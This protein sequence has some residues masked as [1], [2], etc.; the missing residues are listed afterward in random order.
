[1]IWNLTDGNA[2][3]LNQ[4]VRPPMHS[5]A[6]WRYVDVLFIERLVH[7]LEV[8]LFCWPDYTRSS[9]SDFLK[10]TYS[11]EGNGIEPQLPSF[12]D[13]HFSSVREVDVTP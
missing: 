11:Y 7:L 6:G 4:A 8:K 10:M 3:D 1:M 2:F 12:C 5:A 13:Q 9:S